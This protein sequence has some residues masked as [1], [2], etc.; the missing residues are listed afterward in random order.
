M[1]NHVLFDFDGTLIDTNELIICALKESVKSVLGKEVT[2]DDLMAVLGKYLDEQMK[3]FDEEKHEKMVQ[4]YKEYYRAHQD[5]MVKKFSGIDELLM[6][7][8][9]SGRKI[10][11]TSA[12]GRGGIMHGLELFNIKQYIDFI[13]SAYD[14][15][16]NKPHPESVYK[17]L[18][19]FKCDKENM[20]LV[21]DSPYDIQCGINADIKTALVSWTIFSPEK[22]EGIRP[23]YILQK[24]SD[25]IE[26]VK[27]KI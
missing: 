1:I 19:F 26:I 21:G 25:L 12:K 20:I 17:A 16:N 22:F 2:H 7:L 9:Q 23:D 8:K 6:N 4:L 3:Y 11:I 5:T 24:P 14:V 15:E 10:A 27:V 18:D 13:V